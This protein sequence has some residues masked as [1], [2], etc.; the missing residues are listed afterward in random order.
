MRE[1]EIKS[2]GRRDPVITKGKMERIRIING[3]YEEARKR[4]AA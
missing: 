1:L 4:N 3:V 2:L